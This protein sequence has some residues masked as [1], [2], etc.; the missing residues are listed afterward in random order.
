MTK[1]KIGKWSE[2]SVCTIPEYLVTKLRLKMWIIAV[3]VV[4][5]TLVGLAM[6][7]KIEVLNEK[8]KIVLPYLFVQ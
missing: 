6:E 8:W 2:I 5:V 7:G 1:V 3:A 4:C